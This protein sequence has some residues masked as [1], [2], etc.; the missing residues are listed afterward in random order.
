MSI[1]GLNEAQVIASR[2]Q[3]GNNSL[4]QIM[5]DPLWKKIL[6]GFKDPMIMILLVALLIQGVLYLLGQ[7]EWYE[8]V[9]VL[10]AILLANGVA[11]ISENQQEGKAVTLRQDEAAKDKTK[12][13]RNDGLMEI[14][15]QDVVVGDMVFLQ[16]GDRLPADGE[17]AEG[18]GCVKWRN[19][20]NSKIICAR[21]GEARL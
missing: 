4:T 13:Y 6:Q 12:V 2:E 10:V 17:I 21:G 16:A 5:P 1:K 3:H 19:R 20:R 7:A 18:T 15:V 14:P 8:A 11:A 9:G